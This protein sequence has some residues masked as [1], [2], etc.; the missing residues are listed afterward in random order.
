[1]EA[2]VYKL[3]ILYATNIQGADANMFSASPRTSDAYVVVSYLGEELARSA[4]TLK[5]TAPLFRAQMA[6]PTSPLFSVDIPHAIVFASDS[7]NPEIIIELHDRV[8]RGKDIILGVASLSPAD[9]RL[10]VGR[11]IVKALQSKESRNNNRSSLV[12]GC[13]LYTSPSPR[14]S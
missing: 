10:A 2:V 3:Q 13:L 1:M 4:V 5:S 9:L 6:S 14:D 12:G 7:Q 8:P 11:R